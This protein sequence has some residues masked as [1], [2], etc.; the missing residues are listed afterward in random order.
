[1]PYSHAIIAPNVVARVF[2]TKKGQDIAYFEFAQI[3][4][5]RLPSVFRSCLRSQETGVTKNMYR[6]T[7]SYG[8]QAV[9]G[10]ETNV[11]IKNAQKHCKYKG[12]L[13]GHLRPDVLPMLSSQLFVQTRRA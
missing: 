7:S 10:H 3:R 1:M 13:L 12:F 9:M 2:R 11:Q 6:K 8:A 4:E 5:S